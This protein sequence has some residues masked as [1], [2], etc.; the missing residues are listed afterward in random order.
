MSPGIRQNKEVS[1]D[2]RKEEGKPSPTFPHPPP[3]QG[4]GFSGGYRTQ[5]HQPR[6]YLPAFS[7]CDLASASQCPYLEG[8][9][10]KRYHKT[11]PRSFELRSKQLFLLNFLGF[12]CLRFPR[13]NKVDGG[14]PHPALCPR[15][16]KPLPSRTR[17]V[18]RAG[19]PLAAWP[20]APSIMLASWTLREPMAT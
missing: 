5:S 3:S 7:T 14:S 2:G 9:K 10:C 20:K 8:I 16:R 11:W 15:S 4:E 12:L 6:A 13:N 17:G 1:G 19:P 18:G